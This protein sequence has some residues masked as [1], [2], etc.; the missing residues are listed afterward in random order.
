MTKE[1]RTAKEIAEEI[2]GLAVTPPELLDMIQ[3]DISYEDAKARTAERARIRKLADKIVHQPVDAWPA[4]DVKWDLDPNSY[5]WMFDGA[6]P[7][8]ANPA[9]YVLIENVA[10]ALIDTH[11]T[12]YW[13]RTPE[14]LWTIG[15][16]DKSARAI[17]HWSEGRVM[18]PPFLVPTDD[19]RL[20]I[21]G[22]NHRLAVCRTKG[23]IA[24]P[25]L[26]RRIHEVK[27]REILGI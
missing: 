26:I 11:L 21:A 8:S 15:D 14:E 7:G 4:F 1:R 17:V 13:H 22:G 18:S 25:I 16:P 3:H 6:D 20:A 23:V 10:I 9:D 19:N 12:P 5:Y 2:A 27:I 24:L